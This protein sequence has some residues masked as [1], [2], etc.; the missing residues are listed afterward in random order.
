[1]NVLRSGRHQI[2]HQ[3]RVTIVGKTVSL[4]GTWPETA[5]IHKRILYSSERRTAE[6]C[7]PDVQ[8][9][10]SG[11]VLTKHHDKGTSAGKPGGG[12]ITLG[13]FRPRGRII[14]YLTVS[15]SSPRI[16]YH[17]STPLR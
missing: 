13:A 3:L 10:R 14:F 2:D 9:S 4:F 6:E 11:K 8:V 7:D 12:G 17:L 5:V 16:Q 15:V 1:M